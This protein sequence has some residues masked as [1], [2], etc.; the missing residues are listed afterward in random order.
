MLMKT[1]LK[2]HRFQGKCRKSREP[3]KMCGP[4]WKDGFFVAAGLKSEKVEAGP[5]QHVGGDAEHH[6]GEDIVQSAFLCG[7]S[8]R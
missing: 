6:T 7:Q 5:H 8:N 3:N 1:A 2:R 4:D